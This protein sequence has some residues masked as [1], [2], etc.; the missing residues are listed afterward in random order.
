M[1]KKKYIYIYIYFERKTDS[2]DE[3][4][5]HNRINNINTINPEIFEE[6]TNSENVDKMEKCNKQKISKF[7]WK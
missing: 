1:Y 6:V 2:D 7:I 4:E 3:N 5:S